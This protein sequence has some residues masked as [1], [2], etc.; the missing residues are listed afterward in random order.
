M[1]MKAKKRYLLLSFLIFLVVLS[2]MSANAAAKVKLSKTKVTLTAGK[3]TTLK[4]KN[5]KKKVKWSSSNKKIAT[6]NSEGK[7]SAKKKGT[8]KITAKAGGKK[9]TCKV[10]VKAAPKKTTAKKTKPTETEKQTEA[11]P[12]DPDICPGTGY[13]HCWYSTGVVIQPSTC[14][15][16]GIERQACRYCSQTR[17]IQDLPLNPSE[18]M[19]TWGAPVLVKKAGS[20]PDRLN[21]TTYK[22]TCTS[23]GLERT[24]YDTKDYW[25]PT[26]ENQVKAWLLEGRNGGYNGNF[27]PGNTGWGCT[28]YAYGLDGRVWGNYG[29]QIHDHR[30][31]SQLKVGD[32]LKAYNKDGTCRHVQL[33]WDVQRDASGKATAYK[34]TEANVCGDMTIY[35]YDEWRQIEALYNSLTIDSLIIETRWVALTT[36]M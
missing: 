18:Q 30:D 35:W 29:G 8:A 6:V 1:K 25:L 32:I 33:V 12:T 21:P 10:T 26:S 7:V 24:Y 15:V 23:C 14:A 27:K 9:Y 5:N 13:K 31:P 20:D 16:K 36:V 2:P 19:H 22:K 3:T 28:A 17:D 4:L 34:I 11:K